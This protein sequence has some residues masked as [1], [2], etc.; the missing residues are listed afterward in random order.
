MAKN[1]IFKTE[2]NVPA[3]KLNKNMNKNNFFAV[4]KSLTNGVRSGSVGQRCGSADPDPHQNVTDP[5]NEYRESRAKVTSAR[6]EYLY[7]TQRCKSGM[8]ILNPGI[9]IFP[10]RIRIRICNKEFMQH[11]FYVRIM[12]FEKG[13]HALRQNYGSR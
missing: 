6:N 10:S 1:L 7:T 9:R 13:A 12:T 2:D 11:L 5:N 4:L 3:G 8:F